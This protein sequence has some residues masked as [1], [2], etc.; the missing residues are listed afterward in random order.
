MFRAPIILSR[1]TETFSQ[2]SIKNLR[3]LGGGKRGDIL[4]IRFSTGELPPIN[5]QVLINRYIRTAG[6]HVFIIFW[7]NTKWNQKWSCALGKQ[8]YMVLGR[9]TV[10]HTQL[11]W[12]C[13]KTCC[14]LL[15]TCNNFMNLPYQANAWFISTSTR[16]KPKMTNAGLANRQCRIWT[17]CIT[18]M[19]QMKTLQNK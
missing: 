16:T 19:T 13:H 9:Q 4:K 5:M 2:M 10:Y 1:R 15:L 11:Y 8:Y 14:F 3:H 12:Y 18:A 17:N 7:S 6:K